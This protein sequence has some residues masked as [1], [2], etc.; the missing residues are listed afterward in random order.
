M[1]EDF[2][3]LP[4]QEWFK[5]G[6]NNWDV[7][8][9]WRWVAKGLVASEKAPVNI[10]PYAESVLA[11][12]RENPQD[13]YMSM[14]I[15]VDRKYADSIKPGSPQYEAP[16]LILNGVESFGGNA[17]IIDGNHRLAARYYNGENEMDFYVID[18]ALDDALQGATKLPPKKLRKK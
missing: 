9:A 18:G 12:D 7:A 13:R 5:F 4:E 15:A 14:L 17:L 10:V 16:G 8:K 2:E 3:A 1:V 11:L 6:M